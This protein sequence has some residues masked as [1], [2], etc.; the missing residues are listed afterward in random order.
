MSFVLIQ[1]YVNAHNEYIFAYYYENIQ[2][3]RLLIS[4]LEAQCMQTDKQMNAHVCLYMMIHTL[5]GT[6]I[7]ALDILRAIIQI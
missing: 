7:I 4:S 3:M 5:P 1:M 6:F 2:K